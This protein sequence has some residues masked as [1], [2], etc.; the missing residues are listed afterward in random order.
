MDLKT[1]TTW[2]DKDYHKILDESKNSFWFGY[3]YC[4]MLDESL[5]ESSIMTAMHYFKPKGDD[6]FEMPRRLTRLE[7]CTCQ[8]QKWKKKETWKFCDFVGKKP[9]K[10]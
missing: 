7:T 1:I 8:L 9:D 3:S 4:K 2:I 10:K 5:L 6:S